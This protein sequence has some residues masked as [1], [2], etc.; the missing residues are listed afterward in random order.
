MDTLSIYEEMS[1]PSLLSLFETT[2][3]ERQSFIVKVVEALEAGQVDPLKVHLQAKCLESIVKELNANPVYKST[4]LDA[5]EKY[6]KKS[7]E[8][9]NSKMEIKEVGTKYDF[10]KCADP[11][12][13]ALYVK[14]AEVDKLVKDRETFLKTVPQKGMIV[15]DEESGETFTCYPP[16]KSSTTSVVTTLK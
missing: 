15:T 13:E 16:S 2:K 4:V 1:A 3:E 9:S 10:S 7:F 11:V 6:G 5:A 14:Q 8:F 12:L